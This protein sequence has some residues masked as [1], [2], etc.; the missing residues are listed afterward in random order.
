MN[1]DLLPKSTRG[2]APETLPITRWTRQSR[3]RRAPPA[4]EFPCDMRCLTAI[5]TLPDQAA[6]GGAGV[7]AEAA[8]SSLRPRRAKVL[9]EFSSRCAAGRP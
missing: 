6:S 8:T 7:P 2:S 3:T 1:S 5:A 9:C 4:P